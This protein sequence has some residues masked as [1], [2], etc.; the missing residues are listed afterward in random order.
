MSHNTQTKDVTIFDHSHAFMR[1]GGDIDQTMKVTGG[2]LAIGNHCL[3]PV[4]DSWSGFAKWRDRLRAIPDYYLEGAVEAACKV[5][6]PQ[7]RQ[8]AIVD[9]A[10]KRRDT[11]ADLIKSNLAAFPKLPSPPSGI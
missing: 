3:A 5:G 11:L 8:M 9:F 4:L 6:W 2:T 7:G 1:P 10:K